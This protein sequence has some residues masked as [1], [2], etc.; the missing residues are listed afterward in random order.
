[1]AGAVTVLLGGPVMFNSCPRSQ[2]Q[3]FCLQCGTTLWHSMRMGRDNSARQ[4]SSCALQRGCCDAR[5]CCVREADR[6]RAGSD[7]LVPRVRGQRESRHSA[8]VAG[9]DPID[10]GRGAE[11]RA[12]GRR[13]GHAWLLRPSSVRESRCGSGALQLAVEIHMP[14]KQRFRSSDKDARAKAKRSS[15]SSS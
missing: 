9:M 15:L 10:R 5:Q 12:E 11:R 8:N 7:L 4:R 3:A 14:E 6:G 1:M 13:G 2:S